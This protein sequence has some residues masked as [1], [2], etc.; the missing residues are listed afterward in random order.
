MT[1]VPAQSS[2]VLD[3][4]AL[5]LLRDGLGRYDM[6]IRWMA[7]LDDSN[8]LHLWRSWTGHQIYEATVTLDQSQTS[9]AIAALKVEQDK[10][11]YGGSIAG[12]PGRFEMILASLL[13][14]LRRFRAGHTPYG[15]AEGAD[16]VPP[17]WPT[18]DPGLG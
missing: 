17:P 18:P 9:G 2:L 12:E 16:P 10:G 8:T 5:G 7:H 3:H 13:D 14:T 15:P 6:E 1:P 11:R 4:D